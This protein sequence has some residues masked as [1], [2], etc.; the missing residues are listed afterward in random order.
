MTDRLTPSD[1]QI[2]TNTK[3]GVDH[4][5]LLNNFQQLRFLPIMASLTKNSADTDK[6]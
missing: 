2:S 1:Y 4:K 6:A 3:T 5:P